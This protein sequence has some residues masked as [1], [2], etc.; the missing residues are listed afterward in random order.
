MHGRRA[1][2]RAPPPGL[3]E[4]LQAPDL[5]GRH[6]ARRCDFQLLRDGPR[7][8]RRRPRNGNVRRAPARGACGLKKR[9]FPHADMGGGKRRSAAPVAGPPC[10]AG[11]PAR[12]PAKVDQVCR[13]AVANARSRFAGKPVDYAAAREQTRPGGRSGERALI[14]LAPCQVLSSSR[15]DRGA[16]AKR[17]RPGASPGPARRAHPC[18]APARNAP[19]LRAHAGHSAARGVA[20]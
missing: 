11:G 20:R 15:G 2:A 13:H 19:S 5:A 17:R 1:R 12:R 10:G 16:D 3:A 7:R 6:W 14:G 8:G 9:A 4:P 18:T